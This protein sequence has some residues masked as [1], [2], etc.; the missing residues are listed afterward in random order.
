MTPL[1]TGSVC[2]G[3]RSGVRRG[4]VVDTGVHSQGWS[5]ERAIAYLHD[6]TALP[7]HEIANRNAIARSRDHPGNAP[8]VDD[9]PRRTPDLVPQHT[10]PVVRGVIHVHL[11]PQL[12]RR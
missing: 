4:L 6:Y 2:W 9:Q 7:E 1:T 8:G 5:R 11:E 3:T 10:E 12:A